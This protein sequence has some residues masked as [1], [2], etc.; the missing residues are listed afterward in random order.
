VAAQLFLADAS[1]W[2]RIA[3]PSYIPSDSKGLPQPLGGP[4][5]FLVTYKETLI[6]VCAVALTVL[7]ENHIRT[8]WWCSPARIGTATMA[9]DR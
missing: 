3:R 8:Y 7:S 2:R 1:R 6:L 9:P 4:L 5:G